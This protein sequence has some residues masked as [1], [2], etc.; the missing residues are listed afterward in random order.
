[1]LSVLL[2]SLLGIQTSE[3][4]S[5][6][7]P[8]VTLPKVLSVLSEQTGVPHRASQQAAGLYVF[9]NVKD[10]P[11]A[12]L[13]SHLA[14]VMHGKWSEVD[15]QLFFTAPTEE[16]RYRAIRQAEYSEALKRQDLGP[17]TREAVIK[18]INEFEIFWRSSSSFRASTVYRSQDFPRP[19]SRFIWRTLAAIGTAELSKIKKGEVRVFSS[20][21]YMHFASQVPGHEEK[22]RIYNQER[23]QLEEIAA[24]LPNP[25]SDSK[26]V[27][28][29][30]H[31]YLLNRG[32]STE[33]AHYHLCV[34]FND[35][36][37]GFYISGRFYD[38]LGNPLQKLELLPFE[39]S[40][41]GTIRQASL[42]FENDSAAL[43]AKFELVAE[44]DS[45]FL[46]A[47]HTLNYYNFLDR[48]T[49]DLRTDRQL[50]GS[51]LSRAS[52]MDWHSRWP[53]EF[54]RFFAQKTKRQIVAAVSR[55][56]PGVYR[57]LYE[58]DTV[59]SILAGHSAIAALLAPQYD[60]K[61]MSIY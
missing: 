60:W 31:P 47:L 59:G 16:E 7:L 56:V 28:P 2:A 58:V 43:G 9:V 5:L 38:R 27:N 52:R 45:R 51:E 24:S 50:I 33:A 39:S 36:Y 53:T 40:V 19:E 3:I 12:K 37:G 10:Q 13:R 41:S 55:S 34:S 8:I 6:D 42:R 32:A 26:R 15:G 22:L 11:A 23:R 21:P 18:G 35:E 14:E 17:L 54:L 25:S 46:K 57:G 48:G 44:R 1:M 61:I 20:G 30:Y 49:E 4:V 29:L